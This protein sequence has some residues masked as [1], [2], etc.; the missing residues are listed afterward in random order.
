MTH[1]LFVYI[2]FYISESKRFED[3]ITMTQFVLK[4]IDLG[5]SLGSLLKMMMVMITINDRWWK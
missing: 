3:S 4:S 5:T 2:F 1:L